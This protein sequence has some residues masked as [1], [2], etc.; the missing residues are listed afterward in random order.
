M[1]FLIG[2]GAIL[3]IFHFF[4]QKDTPSTFAVQ[5]FAIA[6]STLTFDANRRDLSLLS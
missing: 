5:P 2:W 1:M 3:T 4:N 6:L